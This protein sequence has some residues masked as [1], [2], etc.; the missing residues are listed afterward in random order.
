MIV[1]MAKIK[2]F[3]NYE[4]FETGEVVSLLKREPRILKPIRAGQYVGLSLLRDDGLIERVYVHRVICEAFNGP[5]PDGLQCRHIDGDKTNNAASNL[6]WGT[7]RENEDDKRMHGTLP[8][9]EANPMA[10]LSQQRVR[11]MRSVRAATGDSY[12]R[13]AKAFG[14]STMTAFRAITGQSWREV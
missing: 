5:C 3:P 4:F 9:G 6:A 10:K 7:K 2:R 8:I 13:I 11:D 1:A 14:V 12:A